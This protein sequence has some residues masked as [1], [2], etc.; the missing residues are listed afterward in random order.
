MQMTGYPRTRLATVAIAVLIAAAC[1]S[2]TPTT[3]TPPNTGPITFTA[4]LSAANEVPPL[5]NV[6]VNGRGLATLTM[7]VPR[8][9]AT[10]R[11][12]GGGSI[13]FSVPLSNFPGGTVVRLARIYSGAAGVNGPIVVE[14]GLST[15]TALTLD[16]TG[17]G[18]LTLSNVPVTQ[19]DATAIVANPAAYYLN[20]HTVAS[21]DGA[22]RGQLVRQ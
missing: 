1:G 16:A 4:Q 21:P 10:G 12:T 15:A 11:V 6:D 20:V 5:T 13:N 2:D 9:S 22:A 14:T 17:A 7:T 3:P 18:T 19:A 8:D